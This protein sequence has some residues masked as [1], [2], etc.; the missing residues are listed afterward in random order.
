MPEWI[1][2][3]TESFI[4]PDKLQQIVDTF[5]ADYDKRKDEVRIQLFVP[6][7]HLPICSPC[8]VRCNC[9]FVC[10]FVSGSREAEKGG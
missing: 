9:F 10:L 1:Q 3:Y 8:G 7:G 5:M 6:R 4:Q 2:K